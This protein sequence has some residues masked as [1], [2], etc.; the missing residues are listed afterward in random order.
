MSVLSRVGWI[1]VAKP[2]IHVFNTFKP[3]ETIKLNAWSSKQGRAIQL[4]QKI[5]LHIFNIK[6]MKK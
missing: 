5:I 6:F 1:S 3:W 4:T 2:W